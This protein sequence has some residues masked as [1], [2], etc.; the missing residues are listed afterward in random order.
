MP[1]G[2]LH[3][4]ITSSSLVCLVISSTALNAQSA[5]SSAA[6]VSPSAQTV[7]DPGW[8]RQVEKNGTRLVYYQPQVDSWD[9]YQ[10]VKA[11][12]AFSL[13]PPQKKQALGVVSIEAGTTVDKETRTVYLHDLKFT[14]I[15]FA[16]V[17]P[18]NEPQLEQLFRATVPTNPEPIALDRLLAD[19]NQS[20]RQVKAPPL[21]NDPPQIFY[22]TSPAI[23][24]LVQGQPVLSPIEKTDLQF[25][26]NTNWDVFFEKSKKSYYLLN[27]NV[28][29]TSTEL[30]G[31][32]GVA[33]A[34]PKDVSK[35]PSGENFDD[36]KKAIPPTAM[37]GAAPQVFFSNTPAELLLLRGTPVYTRI[38]GT[39]LLYV[40]NTDDDIFLDDVARQYYV[41]LSGRW[42]RAGAFNGPWEYASDK[43]PADFMKIPEDSPKARV[44]AS[45]P[46]T[47]QA[48]DA[49]MLAQIP[50]TVTV[51]R[52]EAEAK[53]K[54]T[55]DGS[56][57]FKPIE[58]TNLQYATNTQDKV[59]KDGDVYYLCFQG[60]WFMS[61][62]PNGP[63]KTASSVPQEIYS[64]PPSSPVYNV[65]YVTQTSPTP[66]TVESSTTAGYFGMFI[67]GAAVGAAIAYGS[68]YYYP[69]YVYWGPQAVYPIYRP[70]PATYGAG[71]VYNPWNGGFAAGRVAYGPYGAV[72][73]SAWYN[74]ATGR[75][76]RSAS[77]QGV[78]GGRTVSQA[79]NPW[80]GGY[81]ATS[82]AH[83]AYA[84]WG[85]SVATRNGNWAQTGHVTTAN[86]TVAGYRTSTGQRG[87][88]YSRQNG[89]VVHGA[90][91]SVYAGNDGNVYRRNSNDEWSKYDNGSWNTVDTTAAKQQAQQSFQTNH[92]NAQQNAQNFQANHPNAQQNLQTARQNGGS[93]NLG[94][95]RINSSNN[96]ATLQN[97][98]HSAMARQ[99]G[100][101]QTTRFQ[102]FHRGGGRFRR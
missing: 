28:W 96:S 23:L 73:S 22:S 49:V 51:N 91:N 44:L 101:A 76:G 55:Y 66:T 71:V 27:N 60:I 70:W 2:W 26:V 97:L 75:Y 45:V 67:V 5:P 86:G 62:T 41:L 3:R 58:K 43:L 79:Y 72:G 64:I 57:Q 33:K 100:Q 37:T 4:V 89:A 39:R 8:P 14:S 85:S 54:V 94:A 84:Q 10:L 1:R 30:K 32:W 81:G 13:T 48:S 24:L 80:T 65:T 95:S 77:V 36:V 63:W 16:S 61:T 6:V 53:A 21:K 25:I 93:Q 92:P 47:I 50:T 52:A 17:D 19:V 68:G 20:K 7:G 12:M 15:R 29:L 46:G 11:R 35:L 82:Q 42:F 98:D 18:Q 59:I 83:N 56:P 102:N 90:N 40:A 87:T 34:L 69:P 78:Y 38:G 31:P 99:R 88:A 74:P 9:N